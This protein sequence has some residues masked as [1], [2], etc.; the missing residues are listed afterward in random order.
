MCAGPGVRIAGRVMSFGLQSELHVA[1]FGGYLG[2]GEAWGACPSRHRFGVR[3][4]ERFM[5]A[6]QFDT[7]T[8][9]FAVRR[10]TRRT[11]LAAGASIVAAG[12]ATAVAQD[13]SP[14]PAHDGSPAPPDTVGVPFMFVQTF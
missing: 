13:A 2:N 1:R 9:L 14:V 7:I 10:T 12:L 11:A 6:S 4:E 8:R 3:T 5:N